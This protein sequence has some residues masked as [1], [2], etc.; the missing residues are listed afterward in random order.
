MPQGGN[1]AQAGSTVLHSWRRL[2]SAGVAWPQGEGNVHEYE[3]IS[4]RTIY[5][6]KQP[7][8]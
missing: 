8:M 7:L 2:A 5:G 6:K 4:L 1:S 3:A